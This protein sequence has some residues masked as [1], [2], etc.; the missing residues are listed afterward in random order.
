MQILGDDLFTT[1]IERLERGIE[2]GAANAILVKM[3]Q[4]GTISET[5]AVVDGEAR[6]LPNGDLGALW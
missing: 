2:C 4:I 6:R 3:N 1:N 5:L